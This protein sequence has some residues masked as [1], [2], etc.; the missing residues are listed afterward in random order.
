MRARQDGDSLVMEIQDT[1]AGITSED[2]QHLFEPYYRRERD[3]QRLDGLGLGLSLCKR[4]VER[5]GGRIWV[6]SKPGEG[7]TFGF[8]LPLGKPDDLESD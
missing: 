3:R 7:S 8:S 5:H 6:T 2:Q 4:L 1:G